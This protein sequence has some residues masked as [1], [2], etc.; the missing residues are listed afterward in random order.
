MSAVHADFSP[1]VHACPAGQ[2]SSDERAV[3]RAVVGVVKL[4]PAAMLTVAELVG[5][6]RAALP[7]SIVV[8]EPSGQK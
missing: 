6:K 8:F 7:H 4:P 2:G 1:P 5:Q 3:D